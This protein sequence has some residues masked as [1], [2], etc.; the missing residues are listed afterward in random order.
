M[1]AIPDFSGGRAMLE[2]P[3]GCQTDA[4]E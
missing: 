4:P 3:L 1:I 2:P